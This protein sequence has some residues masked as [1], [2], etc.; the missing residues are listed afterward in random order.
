[1]TFTHTARAGLATLAF[2]LALVGCSDNQRMADPMSPTLSESAEDGDDSK[3]YDQIEFL[4]NPLISEVTI[5][6]AN[7]ASSNMTMPYTSATFRPQTE[8]FVTS[9]GR[10]AALATLLGSVLYPDILV[11]DASKNPSTAGWL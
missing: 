5:V 1:M 3:M 7:H 11:V 4:G 2:A 10:P 6:K 9:F 8:A